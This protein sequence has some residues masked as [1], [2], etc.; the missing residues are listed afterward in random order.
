MQSTPAKAPPLAGDPAPSF[1]QRTPA[2]PR[3]AFDSAAGRYLVLCFFGSAG[4]AQSLAAMSA[5]M[6]RSDLFNDQH[7]S[8]F[9]VSADPEDETQAR[10]ANRVPGVRIFWD[11]DLTVAKL[12]GAA[13]INAQQEDNAA[14]IKRFWLVL[15]PTL[16]VMANIPFQPDGADVQQVLALLENAPPPERF[17][18]IELQAPILYL[19]RV[20]E[21]DICRHLIDLYNA[22][23]GYES[24]FMREIGGRT[25]GISDPNHK[26]R[27]DYD[28]TDK[29]LIAALQTRFLRRVVPEIA[30]VHQFVATRMERYIVACYAAEDGG[31]FAPHRDNT[32]KGTAHRRFAVSVNLNDDFDGGEVS[33]PEYG[34]RSFKAPTGGAVV[35]SCSLLH[36]VSRVTRGRRFAFLPFLY[37]DAAAKLREQNAGLIGE[38]GSQ[39]RAG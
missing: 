29:D 20:F 9:G 12:Y 26:R 14:C 17:A 28:I 11:F 33:F 8:L 4:D 10:I 31:H 36:K 21:P 24:G 19:P 13:P 38:K 2:N 30:K 16:R 15:D 35:F 6:A 1:Y 7:A 5:A 23:G 22:T 32:T 39:Y 37:D 18:G 3:Y 27:K 25:M 34:P